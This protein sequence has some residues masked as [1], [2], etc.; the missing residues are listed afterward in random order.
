M[1]Y[2]ETSVFKYTCTEAQITNIL[3]RHGPQESYVLG[4]KKSTKI[5][6]LYFNRGGKT[7]KPCTLNYFLI[8]FSTKIH[9]L[10]SLQKATVPPILPLHVVCEFHTPYT[11]PKK[12]SVLAFVD[13]CQNISQ[14]KSHSM[15]CK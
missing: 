8:V 11:Y 4:K 15:C 9:G 1:L 14:Q 12:L 7:R 6:K 13:R 3:T 5:S 2:A 10:W